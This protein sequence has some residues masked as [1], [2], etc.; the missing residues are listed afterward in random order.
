MYSRTMSTAC[1]ISHHPAVNDLA[2]EN[3]AEVGGRKHVPGDV[4]R[5]W[6]TLL[7]RKILP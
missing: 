6:S 5:I 4:Q 2:I 7:Y 1:G 3:T